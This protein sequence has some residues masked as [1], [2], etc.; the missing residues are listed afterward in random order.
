MDGEE[1][2]EEMSG[3]EEFEQE[4]FVEDMSM[5]EGFEGKGS[6]SNIAKRKGGGANMG[7]PRPGQG[8]VLDSLK[9]EKFK[10]SP[11]GERRVIEIEKAQQPLV[12]KKPLMVKEK[13]NMEENGQGEM[14]KGF[15]L[16]L[17]ENKDSFGGGGQD[18]MQEVALSWKE[19]DK[20]SK[21][22]YKQARKP[23]NY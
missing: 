9:V 14:L 4:I 6:T 16:Y 23:V 10:S 17:A 13:E 8:I 11:T 19:L 21:E 22:K 1:D 18:Q 2:G 5:D 20:E 3:D 12:A 7:S 15:Q